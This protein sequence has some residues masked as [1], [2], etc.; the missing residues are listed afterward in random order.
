M[1]LFYIFIVLF[2]HLFSFGQT[3]DEQIARIIKLKPKEVLKY[4]TK[5]QLFV[6]NLPTVFNSAQFEDAVKVKSLANKTIVKV[7][8]I[9]TMYKKSETFNQNTL[10]KQRL[11]NVYA[12][13]SNVFSQKGIEWNLIAQTGCKDAADGKNF[14]HGIVV[15]YRDDTD[16]LKRTVELDFIKL[17]REKKVKANTY[18]SF[19]KAEMKRLDTS[20]TK[21]SE[22]AVIEKPKMTQPDFPGGNPA[23]MRYFSEG[24]KFP[25]EVPAVSKIVQAEFIVD[26]EGKIKSINFPSDKVHSEYVDEVE[27][28]I[29]AQPLWKPGTIDGEKTE[30]LVRFSVEFH[31]RGSVLV[32]PFDLYAAKTAPEFIGKPSA[33]TDYASLK[34]M[35]N[36]S[37]SVSTVLTKLA[38]S[39]S[40]LVCDVTGSMAMYNAQ[41]I[42]YVE[43]IITNKAVNNCK[44]VVFFNDG[45]NKK[46]RH[47]KSGDTGG[48]YLAP[49]DNVDKL[50][51]E[52]LLAMKNGNGGDLPE[53]NIEAALY[54]ETLC[55]DCEMIIM[56][57]DNFATPRDLELANNL[58]KPLYII[59]CTST[60]IINENYLDLVR[61]TKGI[62]SF[63]NKEYKNLHTFEDGAT[64][65]IGSLVYE[66]HKGKFRFKI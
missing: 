57:A 27:R 50:T 12:V 33:A 13:A 1:K 35:P 11:K 10:N 55:S 2:F 29:K 16:D 26:K 59:L 28:I 66:L 51:T 37:S 58:K 31:T 46:D 56:L 54:A 19:I 38:A 42:E 60:P 43:S 53:N 7:E 4:A 21:V 8:L 39:K 3:I 41:L 61:T 40:V 30:Y 62:L 36:A 9:Y 48:I 25:R 18:E 47:K 14:F 22:T 20:K 44:Q 32:S 17:V 52:M 5:Q 63:Q 23:L 24:I 65:Q 6:L 64:V 15:T 34:P 49:T 45:D